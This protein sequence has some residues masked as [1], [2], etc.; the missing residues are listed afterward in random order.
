[1]VFT[2]HQTPLRDKWLKKWYTSAF[3]SSSWNITYGNISL[4][5]RLNMKTTTDIFLV[6]SS[7][8]GMFF[9]IWNLRLHLLRWSTIQLNIEFVCWKAFLFSTPYKNFLTAVF[10]WHWL[11]T[12]PAFYSWMFLQSWIKPTV[13]HFEISE[14]RKWSY[15]KFS[16]GFKRSL[17]LTFL[18]EIKSFLC[19]TGE[20]NKTWVCENSAHASSYH[21]EA[22]IYLLWDKTIH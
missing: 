18:Q 16:K 13:Q 22:L 17:A 4:S 3:F 21:V 2:R 14:D 5:I 11:L 10:A 19:H 6:R 12:Q 8:A 1:M 20:H 9:R 15:G 7:M